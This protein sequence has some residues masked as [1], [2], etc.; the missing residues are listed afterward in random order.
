MCIDSAALVAPLFIVTGLLSMV[1]FG[2]ALSYGVT[3]EMIGKRDFGW[4][5]WQATV[6]MAVLTGGGV[7]VF[8]LGAT[9]LV[10]V[11]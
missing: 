6:I 8:V 3:V 7:M 4:R 5:N 9:G 2:A 11:R 1:A 10:E